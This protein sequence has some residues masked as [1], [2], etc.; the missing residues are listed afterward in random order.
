MP[1]K[2]RRRVLRRFTDEFKDRAVSLVKLGQ[3]VSHVARSLGIHRSSLASWVNNPR[4]LPNRS[5]LS[6]KDDGDTR[7]T[8]NE[9]SA[10][11]HAEVLCLN[12][13]ELIRK[14]RCS[15]C[16]EVMMCACDQ[17]HGERFLAHQT[18][19]GQE[20][21]TKMRVP[22]TLGFRP[23]V[24][25][26]CRGLPLIAAPKAAI[27]GQTSKIRRF[28]WRELHFRHFDLLVERGMSGSTDVPESVR[29][30]VDAQALADIK[31]LHA[32]RPK[33][34]METES[35]AA[36]LSRVPVVILDVQA[37]TK[38]GGEVLREDGTSCS[39][40]AFAAEWLA[41]DGYSS[42]KCESTPMHTLFAVLLWT[43]LQDPADP[44]V[45]LVGFGERHSFERSGDRSEVVWTGLP[46]DFGGPGYAKRRAEQI[47][48]FFAEFLQGENTDLLFN[49][50][51]GIDGSYGLR[52]YLWAHRDEDLRRARE[53]LSVV[54]AD[55]SRRALRYLLDDYWGHYLG[56]PDIFAWRSN[57]FLFVE[58]KLSGD[59]L[60]D[61]QRSW[62]EGNS[63]AMRF[64]FKVFKIRKASGTTR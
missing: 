8:S 23:A 13:Y 17:R 37:A 7:G 59:K 32:T 50:D 36:F 51:I 48:E 56:W 47:E 28:Y 2:E 19:E 5:R 25:R 11:F 12:E 54:P 45:R 63:V 26:E 15:A 20:S 22:V 55:H 16:G 40:E 3:S 30:D 42:I 52:Q 61:E 39:P 64:P 44:M 4:T 1:A 29:Q 27:Y 21:T 6:G 62:I 18:H 34:S 10:C 24:C 53:I 38:P 9:R 35:E 41:R 58:V 46:E 60:S 14:Y 57:E 31:L 43:L 33:Y 49:F